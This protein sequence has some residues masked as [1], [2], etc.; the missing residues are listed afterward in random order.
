MAARGS[1]VVGGEGR[2]GGERHTARGGA[3]GETGARR[4]RVGG[5]IARAALSAGRLPGRRATLRGE[6][7]DTSGAD[8]DGMARPARRARAPGGGQVCPTRT[9]D[10][11]AGLCAAVQAATTCSS[12]RRAWAWAGCRFSPACSFNGCCSLQQPPAGAG[13]LTALRS[14]DQGG[15]YDLRTLEGSPAAAPIAAGGGRPPAVCSLR[16]AS[17]ASSRRC[18]AGT[19]RLAVWAARSGITDGRLSCMCGWMHAAAAVAAPVASTRGTIGAA[20]TGESAAGREVAAQRGCAAA[21]RGRACKPSA[22]C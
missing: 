7:A 4:G 3:W 19:G 11:P 1:G 16:A 8:A 15:C 10:S 6:S 12:C 20:G 13:Q 18:P 14:L 21:E 9:C 17:G 5:R 22:S 2:G